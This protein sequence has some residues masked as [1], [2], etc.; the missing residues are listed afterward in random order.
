MKKQFRILAGLA[1]GLGFLI[2]GLTVWLIIYQDGS[3]QA[4]KEAHHFPWITLMPAYLLPV[5]IAVVARRRR[6]AAKTAQKDTK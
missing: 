6:E 4:A 1:I 2:M 5:F 3:G